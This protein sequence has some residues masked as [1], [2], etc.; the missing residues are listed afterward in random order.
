MSIIYLIHY[1]NIC[2]LTD[3]IY[4]LLIKLFYEYVY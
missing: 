3:S 4:K 1:I 2:W